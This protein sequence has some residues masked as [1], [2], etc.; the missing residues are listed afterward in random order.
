MFQD[1]RCYNQAILQIICNTMMY[2]LI[3]RTIKNMVH[4]ERCSIT[5]WREFDAII[6]SDFI[7]PSD[8]PRQLPRCT[9]NFKQSRIRFEIGRNEARLRL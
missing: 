7:T 3:Q 9:A 5:R 1:M 8:D 2:Q 6:A 4:M